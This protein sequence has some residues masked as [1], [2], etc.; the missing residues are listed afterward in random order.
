GRLRCPPAGNLAESCAMR[1][2][3][4]GRRPAKH[5]VCHH[6]RHS[7]PV[8]TRLK[9]QRS[10]LETHWVARPCWYSFIFDSVF[11]QFAITL[12]PQISDFLPCLLI[13]VSKTEAQHHG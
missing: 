5:C 3:V 13:M 10:C 6:Y 12:P 1:P 8:S 4:N 2:L 9:S 11:L 7:I